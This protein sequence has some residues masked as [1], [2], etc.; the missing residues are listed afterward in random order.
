MPGLTEARLTSLPEMFLFSEVHRILGHIIEHNTILKS[1]G[2]VAAITEMPR[3][4]AT[5]KVRRF[6]EMVTYYARFIQIH[7]SITASLNWLLKKDTMF[8]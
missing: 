3:S 8:K 4:T 5:E 7:L 6:L 2:K 1:P